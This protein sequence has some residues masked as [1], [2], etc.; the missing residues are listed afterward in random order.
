MLLRRLWLPVT[1]SLLTLALPGCA[2]E[3]AGEDAEASD[4]NFSSKEAVQLDFEF[5]GELV[6][7]SSWGADQKIQDQFLYTIGHLNHDRSVGRLDRLALSNVVTAAQGDGSYRIT[8]H[9]KFP[10]AWGKR[11]AVPATY[12]FTLPKAVSYAGLESFTSKYKTKC[13]DL[14]AHDVDSG[15]MWYYYR[16][17]RSGCAIDATDV[18]K[19]TATVARSTANTTGK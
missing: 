2:D 10:V 5:D 19:L 3:V 17:N 14:G 6:T 16:P 7:D 1:L 12:A 8:Y 11:N 4:Q 18:V 15:S 9:A 13:V